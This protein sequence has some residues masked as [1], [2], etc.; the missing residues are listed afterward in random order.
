MKVTIATPFGETSFEMPQEKAASLI[1]KAFLYAAEGSGEEQK[2]YEVKTAAPEEKRP[3]AGKPELKD[4]SAAPKADGEPQSEPKPHT[5]FL[6]IRCAHC[7]KLRDFCAK[8]PVTESSCT[9]GKK[10]PLYSLRPAYLEC[11]CG[12]TWRYRTNANEERIEYR[13]L[14]CGGPVD[15]ELNRKKNA[16]CT[17]SDK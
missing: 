15:L 2:P 7:G 3:E 4:I 16:Y 17:I 10:T 5:G 11:K 12:A 13:C 6:L 8:T 1:Q 9:C 14:S